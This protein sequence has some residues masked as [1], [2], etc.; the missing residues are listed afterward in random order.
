MTIGEITPGPSPNDPTNRNFY[1]NPVQ[2]IGAPKAVVGKGVD[3]NAP[4]NINGQPVIDFDLDSLE[5]KAWRKPG[6]ELI[7]F[8]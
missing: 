3:L 1:R 5:E 8:C 6:E 4:G 2:V 7:I